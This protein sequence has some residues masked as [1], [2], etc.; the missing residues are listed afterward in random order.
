MDHFGWVGG[1]EFLSLPDLADL[2]IIVK[3]IEEIAN[4]GDATAKGEVDGFD[5]LPIW[6]RPVSNDEGVGV[7]NAG[8]EMEN[9]GVEDTFLEHEFG[10]L[11][12]RS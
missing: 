12:E 10:W 5:F 2:K 4:R 3:Q 8:E 9:V 1:E 7:T 6:K 11:L